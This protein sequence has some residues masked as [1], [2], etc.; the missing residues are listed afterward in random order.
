MCV[1]AAWSL[2]MIAGG[3]RSLSKAS[4]TAEDRQLE[5]APHPAESE[6]RP[7][8]VG[9]ADL[10]MYWQ[11]FSARPK[12][13]LRL[14]RSWLLLLC[15][16][17]AFASAPSAQQASEASTDQE[18]PTQTSQGSGAGAHFS[19]RT[20]S[21]RETL[22]SF[23]E[24]GEQVRAALTDYD[25]AHDREA[26]DRLSRVVDQWI[27]LIDL[28]Q[29]PEA[30]R[31]V[32]GAETGA[33]LLDIFNRRA[34]PELLAVPDADAF[35]KDGAVAYLVPGTPF[36]VVPMAT[37][38]RQG[39]FLFSEN[40]VQTAPRFFQTVEDLPSK[41]RDS[42]DTAVSEFRRLTGP[43]VPRGLSG[44]VPQNLEEPI[45]GTPIWKIMAVL[46][47]A[48][49]VALLLFVWNRVTTSPAWGGLVGERWRRLLTPMAAVLALFGLQYYFV[50]EIILLGQF[51]AG[52]YTVLTALIFLAMAWGFWV[53]VLAAFETA[54]SRSDRPEQG[55][56]AHMLRLIARL[57]GFVG[58]VIILAYG[59]QDVGLPV[60]S[61]LAGLGIGG[62]AIALA[63]RP[64]LENLIGGFVLFLD[65]PIRVGDFC[66]FGTQSGTVESI[67]VRSSQIRAADR[68]LI[69]VPNA[70]FADMQIIN[71][72]K[73]DR[74][75]IK[76]TLGLRYETN[77]DQLRFVLE[78]L[79]IMLT[80]HPRI[81]SETVR[82]RFS[83]FG[84]SSLN[85][86]I[87]AY[88]LT[89]DWNDFFAIR[90]AIQLRIMAIVGESGTAL[91]F[92]SQTLY[93]TKDT[94]L[95]AGPGEKAT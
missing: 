46:I 83:D 55:F 6:P 71:W 33:Y 3:V 79:R 61:L 35:K 69:T 22:A 43:L 12:L 60:F 10:S 18:G 81:D 41:S 80:E 64:T 94:G 84:T 14:G 45:L 62:L 87:R 27:S 73:C 2:R 21:P 67:G 30:T 52:V 89:Q 72:A 54:I 40:T 78:K 93:M 75:L 11:P 1:M 32:V 37:G 28:S 85:V 70:Q 7:T 24:L 92:P 42:V 50:S 63:I 68:S 15:M 76:Q 17:L 13:F 16:M 29:V 5:L 19:I 36:R 56:D 57:L 25:A 90:E 53:F 58:G 91:A 34:P 65:R 59:A 49:A 77:E 74:M 48:S 9:I 82:A 31:Q 51:A 38:P 23:L 20:S 8:E 39:E 44:A 47:L 95:S 26:A 66:T 4:H 88:V 86:D